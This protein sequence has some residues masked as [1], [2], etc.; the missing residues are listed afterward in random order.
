M[1]AEQRTPAEVLDSVFGYSS[2]RGQQEEIIEHL[3]T[4]GDAVVLMPT[5]GGKSLCYQIPALVRPGTG[6]V[7]S[8]LIAL[9][10]DQVVALEALGVKA[11]YLNSSLSPEEA[12]EVQARFRSG[13]LD[14]LYLAP[15]RLVQE[16]TL[17]LLEQTEVSL[18]AIDEAHCVSQW[19]HDF[20][21]DYLGLSVLHERFPTVPR[22]ALTATAAP[23]AHDE[24]TR[25]LAMGEARHFVS[26]FDRPNIQYRIAEKTSPRR[27]LVE[28]IKD[29]H[30]GEAGIVYCLSRKSTEQFADYLCE[31]G[32]DAMAY[33]AGLPQ[34]E[35]SA[36]QARFLRE[37]GVVMVA[38]IAFG[39]GIDKPDVRFVAHVDLPKSVEGYYQETG[40][41][42]RDG[43]PA[44]AWMVYGLGDVVAQRRLI[45]QSEGSP[46]HRQNLSRHL[47]SMLALCESLTCRRQ[48]I[49]QYFGEESG[50][51]GNCDTCLHPPQAWDATVAVQM[52]LSAIIRLERERG[53]RFGT[54]QIIDVLRGKNNPRSDESD[55]KSLSVWGIGADLSEAQ[56]R[57]VFRQTTARGWTVPVGEYG[58][59]MVDASADPVLRGEVRVELAK[60]KRQT[61]AS[62]AS[63]GSVRKYHLTE[64]QEEIFNRLR[65][66][67]KTTAADSGVPAYVVFPDAALMHIAIAQPQSLAAL[68]K[69]SGVGDK[70]LEAYG[71]E[72]VEI[73]TG[74]DVG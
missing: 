52:L 64:D 60:P 58:V 11:A 5:G 10:E 66:W 39:M 67:R 49:L 35:R 45:S 46:Q 59:F 34:E 62:S 40:R 38:T 6:V 74:A 50:P 53:Q 70:K 51:C 71:T 22:V 32:I 42:G 28:L 57:S 14:L 33:H 31:Q 21:T 56:W 44:T 18:F 54:G 7:I 1:T 29:E 19:G 16:R 43:L 69:V 48:Q 17:R 68:R 63:S 55:H 65:A 26:S 12:H 23:A 9:M 41:A 13:A 4:G 61:K 30:P 3:C 8:P 47:D 36:R 24:L 27:Q 25:R 15:E 72:V 73:V 2:F 37:D 20:R